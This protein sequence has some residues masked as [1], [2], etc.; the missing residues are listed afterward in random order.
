MC[1]W[2]G[3]GKLRYLN[4]HTLWAQQAVRLGRVDPHN[5]NPA[6]LLTKHSI[7]RDRPTMLAELHGCCHR[8]GGAESAPAMRSAD[9][10]KAMMASAG[11]A[12]GAID[13]RSQLYMPHLALSPAELLRRRRRRRR[14]RRMRRRCSTTTPRVN[15]WTRRTGPSSAECRSPR[16]SMDMKERGRLR[17]SARGSEN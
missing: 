7:S 1:N 11:R 14:R 6:D 13:V 16:I 4:T 3:L 15:A 9:Y 12:F 8:D 5:I 2:Q 17:H 10:S